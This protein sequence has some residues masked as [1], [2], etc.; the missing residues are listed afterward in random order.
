MK[1]K[2]QKMIEAQHADLPL[3]RKQTITA[4]ILQAGYTDEK[5]IEATINQL[6]EYKPESVAGY[7]KGLLYCERCN[8][9]YD[10]V[11][12]YAKKQAYYCPRCR[13]CVP[14]A[15]RNAE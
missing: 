8:N 7:T 15:V 2:I 4:S 14:K 13:I 5:D 6:A 9:R 12:L 1:D 11:L 10:H 3:S